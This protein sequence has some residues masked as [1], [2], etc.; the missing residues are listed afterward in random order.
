MAQ[1]RSLN[2]VVY[3]ADLPPLPL[4]REST[5]EPKAGKKQPVAKPQAKPKA[6]PSRLQKEE[7]EEDSDDSESEDE[8][9]EVHRVVK[10]AEKKFQT[11]KRIDEQLEKLRNPY[12][13]KGL[14]VF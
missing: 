8:D 14:S 2:Q 9:E 7:P 12:K 1:P 4:V 3:P 10:K 11:I 13:G 6:K 5:A